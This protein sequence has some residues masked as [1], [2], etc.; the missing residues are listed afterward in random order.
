MF[1]TFKFEKAYEGR[2]Q[3]KRDYLQDGKNMEKLYSWMARNDDHGTYNIIERR[4]VHEIAC[5]H[6]KKVLQEHDRLTMQL[7]LQRKKLEE[8][9]QELG[10]N[11]NSWLYPEKNQVM[12]HPPCHINAIMVKYIELSRF[13]R[14]DYLQQNK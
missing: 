3:G 11:E 1:D 6:L 13:S 10:E 4:K 8:K 12:D 9:E 7:E 14:S 5:G 2:H